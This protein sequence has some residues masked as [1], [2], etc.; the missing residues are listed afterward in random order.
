MWVV[1]ALALPAAACAQ[2]AAEGDLA[3]REFAAT[4]LPV[5]V[6]DG[7]VE[8]AA[9]RVA[10]WEQPAPDGRTITRLVLRGDVRVQLG[11]HRFDAR[12]AVAWIA[13]LPR[14]DPDAGEGVFQVF[15]YFDGVGTPDEDA[16]VALTADRLSVQGIFRVPPGGSV[17]LKYDARSEIPPSDGLVREAERSLAAYLQR[18][19]AGEQPAQD[20]AGLQPGEREQ[21]PPS[22]D[23]A[24]P[25]QPVEE[26]PIARRIAA[27]SARLGPTDRAE[28]IF[29][30]GGVLTV[31]AGRVVYTRAGP[32]SDED[33]LTV[34][35]DD[36][37]PI[38]VVYWDAEH[39]RTLQLTAERAVLFLAA[40]KGGG[41]PPAEA[42]F[43]VEQVRG[44]YLEGD[45]YADDGEYRL[46]SPR[47][48]YNVRENRALLIDAV[49]WTYVQER[50]LNL[51]VRAKTIEQLSEKQFRATRARVTNTAFFDPGLALGA[52]SVTISPPRTEG[53][54]PHLDV[55]NFTVRVAGLPVMWLP[56][57]RG[58][59]T[60]I[61]IREVGIEGSSGK[62]WAVKTTWN[63]ASLLG[64]DLP[65]GQ[66]LNLSID[67]YFER[68]PAFGLDYRWEGPRAEGGAAA[69]ML[70]YDAGSD[71]TS[72]G[73]RVDREGDLR[74]LAVGEHQARLN[75]HW[76]LWAQGFWISDATFV[77]AWY[78]WLARNRR[79]FENSIYVQRAG[80]RSLFT[81]EGKA[82][83]VDFIA[84]EYLLQSQGFAVQRAPE[85]TYARLADNLLGKA[86]PGLLSYSSEHLLGRVAFEFDEEEANDRGFVTFAQA[87][88]LFGILP[89]QSPG[90]ALRAQGLNTEAVTRFDTRHEVSAQLRAGPLSVTPFGVGRLTA[91]DETFESFSPDAD[92]HYRLWGALGAEISTE[93]SRVN[94]RVASRLFDLHR[95]R[96]IV[97]PSLTVWSAGTTIDGQ[98]LPPYDMGVESIAQGDALRLALEQ[99]WQTYRG[100]PGRSRAVDVFTLNAEIVATD[101]T[102]PARSP[103]GRWVAYRPEL[104]SLR[105]FAGLSGTWQVSEVVATAVETVYDMDIHQ[106]ARTSV[107]GMIQHTP[108]FSTSADLRYI[109]SQDQTFADVGLQYILTPKYAFNAYAAYDTDRGE[110]QVI[111]GEIRRAFPNVWLGVNVGYNGINENMSFGIVVQ[112][113]G[114]PGVTG[115]GG[116]FGGGAAFGGGRSPLLGG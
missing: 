46:R 74:M 59:P 55:R 86:A 41:P 98:D 108:D 84:N 16:A 72:T 30:K 5:P 25:I 116:L 53:G 44:L 102:G 112:P 39:Q 77:D 27:A 67:E 91:W 70:P 31:A 106:Q 90:D 60:Q 10:Q 65:P 113:R 11:L 28:P 7:A 29:A 110:F 85:A 18:V 32:G 111:G 107:G 81:A 83:F 71:L 17:V 45:V 109:N 79:E 47:V 9:T 76:S 105:D 15:V 99:T 103:I 75:D 6:M 24:R 42:Q 96:H 21:E 20:L 54:G 23:G 34:T 4:R 51:Y 52:S 64:L 35:G 33:V 19:A 82:L 80:D 114:L 14:E 104:S 115:R 3:T 12:K 73:R 93:I 87:Q 63:A 38:T 13:P 8:F 40:V 50:G 1:A 88:A 43:P 62:G 95:M 78:D 61:P 94:N 97:S 37:H 68:G 49:F 56:R 26:D 2:P 48:Y 57:F 92:E 89:G 101:N 66:T 22:P 36:R 69:Y 58:D 100:G